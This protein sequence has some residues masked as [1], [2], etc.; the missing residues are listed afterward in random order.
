MGVLVRFPCA[1]T[2]D[3]C[4]FLIEQTVRKVP[5]KALKYTIVRVGDYPHR[6]AVLDRMDCMEGA[7]RKRW[8]FLLQQIR[9]LLTAQKDSRLKP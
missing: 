6:L 2:K 4:S 5:S 7:H 3:A 8:A 1:S 9:S